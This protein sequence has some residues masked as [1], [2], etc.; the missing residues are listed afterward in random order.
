MPSRR[1]PLRQQL[2]EKVLDLIAEEAME[3][4]KHQMLATR[5]RYFRIVLA[6]RS[7]YGATATPVGP[8]SSSDLIGS[9]NND[10]SRLPSSNNTHNNK[11]G[12]NLTQRSQSYDV[13]RRPSSR[14]KDPKKNFSVNTKGYDIERGE[15]DIHDRH[16]DGIQAV[17]NGHRAN[18]FKPL[19]L[20]NNYLSGQSPTASH[21]NPVTPAPTI[22]RTPPQQ[23]QQ[24]VQS[25]DPDDL[26]AMG[27]NWNP[28]NG[29]G[30]RS[31]G[32]PNSHNNGN[33]VYQMSQ[34]NAVSTQTSTI[35]S[36]RVAPKAASIGT[37]GRTREQEPKYADPSSGGPPSLQQRI[38]EIAALEQDTIR[39]EK[40]RKVK[41]KPAK[42][43]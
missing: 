38:A 9:Y 22:T 6:A 30:H 43:F 33:L 39:W 36:R 4:V 14:S 3:Q 2:P 40:S 13:E 5:M 29:S 7:G 16:K 8:Y 41:K 18:Y 21:I 1:G 37:Q 24:P 12:S 34:S 31:N 20:R 23:Q 27:T 42:E 15:R 11:N 28:N 10:T 17:T 25:R 32:R 26:V 35:N 19:G